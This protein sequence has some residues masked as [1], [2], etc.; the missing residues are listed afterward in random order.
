MKCFRILPVL[1]FSFLM[2]MVAAQQRREQLKFGNV[3]AEDFIPKQYSIDSAADVIDLYEAGSSVYEGN[4]NGFFSVMYEHHSRMR[5]LHK[6]GFDAASVIIPLYI[7][8]EYQTKLLSIEASTFNL[9]NGQVVETKLD[10]TAV[11]TEVEKDITSYKFTFPNV[12]E[13]SI[14]EFHIKINLPG[15]RFMPSWNFQKRYPVLYSEYEVKVPYFFNYAIIKQGLQNYF[16]DTGTEVRERYYINEKGGSASESGTTI[17]VS[18]Q[19]T[20]HVWAMKDVPAFQPQKYM[21]SA[22][23]YISSIDFQLSEI[24]MPEQEIEKVAQ[25]WYKISEKLLHD[26]DFGLEMNYSNTWLKDDIKTATANATTE[27]EKAQGIY[28]FVRDHYSCND[29]SSRFLSAPLKKIAQFKKGNVADINILLTAMLKQAGLEAYPVILSTRNHG[30]VLQ[31]YPVMRKFNYVIT[32][33]FIND[34]SYYLDATRPN[35]GFNHLPEDCYNGYAR[36][37]ND[38]D[39]LL[40]SFDAD[41]IKEYQMNIVQIQP[42]VVNKSMN[43]VF[44]KSFGNFESQDVRNEITATSIDA[45][46][47]K[48]QQ[49]FNVPVQIKDMHT[50]NLKDLDEPL[51]L[52]YTAVFSMN[53]ND[54]LIYL[55]PVLQDRITENPFKAE[56]RTYPVEIPNCMNSTY[57]LDMDVPA[58]YSVDEL[59]KSARVKLN[60]HEGSFE[61]LIVNKNNHIQMRC[62]LAMNK[63]NFE[64]DEYSTLRDFYAFIVQKENE[65]IVFKKKTGT[66]PKP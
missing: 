64:P 39:P 22:E 43:V 26:P 16:I 24:R 49:Q 18:T 19:A 40:I 5:L 32:C 27:L 38:K 3:T 17:A 31:N 54:D 56:K 53:P 29:Y 8:K 4:N 60:E 65:Q 61:Y 58:G 21:T 28:S 47:K 45:Y 10:K 66:T 42:D 20:Q 59:P 62:R 11:F 63:A 34:A 50:D 30:K 41:S 57:I 9:E 37:I 15:Y 13:G 35:L 7:S 6:N 2:L 55:N 36:V 25:S 52:Q 14:I 33:V 51:K 1:F 48:L 23:N 12:K 46:T 44:N